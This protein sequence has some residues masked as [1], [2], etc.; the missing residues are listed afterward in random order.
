M[1]AIWVYDWSAAHIQATGNWL[2]L[3]GTTLIGN[4]PVWLVAAYGE[5]VR[6]WGMLE[7]RR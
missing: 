4:Y 2:D 6:R 7:L 5:W 3:P 1:V